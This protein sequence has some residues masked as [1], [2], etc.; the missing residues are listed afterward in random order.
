M[1]TGVGQEGAD[2]AVLDLAAPP[3]P[4]AGHAAG[5]VPLLGDAAAVD[6]EG[7]GRSR[8]PVADVA[9]ESG[10]HGPV[11]PGGPADRGLDGLA[12]QAGP[13]GKGLGGLP[14]QAGA[15]TAPD[16]GGVG[17]LLGPV[18]GG[19]GA[20]QRGVQAFGAVGQLLGGQGSLLRQG[21]G[22]GMFQGAG[23]ATSSQG[24]L[25]SG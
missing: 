8:P 15:F 19:Q 11:V 1:P 21:A 9:A 20:L 7:G 22:V 17:A 5:G 2:R 12:L 13:V 3:A 16:G 18:E 6:D 10:P 23:P 14:L 4:R 25:P 24:S